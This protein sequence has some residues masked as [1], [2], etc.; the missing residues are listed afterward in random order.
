MVFNSIC[1]CSII[2]IWSLHRDS[3]IG[4]DQLFEDESRKQL[5]KRYEC[6]GEDIV[7][8]EVILEVVCI[9][10]ERV[11]MSIPRLLDKLT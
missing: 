6:K 3:K 8:G 11:K 1:R 9:R 10:E 7:V 5:V 4:G 2:I